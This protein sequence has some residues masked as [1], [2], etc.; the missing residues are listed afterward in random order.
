MSY[1]NS[2]CTGFGNFGPDAQ[3]P[4]PALFTRSAI[5]GAPPIQG[6]A[7]YS[8]RLVLGG[9]TL[10]LR[11]DVR[12]FTAHNTS[13]NSLFFF[14]LSGADPYI[15]SKRALMFRG[16]MLRRSWIGLYDTARI[17]R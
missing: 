5:P 13:E 17:L 11:A 14:A 4:Y 10:T 15:R 12:F 3:P 6:T 8:H 9:T 1:T 2:A 7:A 16:F